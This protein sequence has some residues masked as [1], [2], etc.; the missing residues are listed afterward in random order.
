MPPPLLLGLVLLV[1]R[2]DTGHYTIL[3]GVELSGMLSAKGDFYPHS[4]SK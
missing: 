2:P 4:F 3:L 1:E